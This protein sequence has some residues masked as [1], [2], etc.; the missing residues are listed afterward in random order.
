MSTRAL[1]KLQKNEPTSK[2]TEKHSNEE[3]HFDEGHFDNRFAMVS[4]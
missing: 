2:E 4:F 1:R 3:D